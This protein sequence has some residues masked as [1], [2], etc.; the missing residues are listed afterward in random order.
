MW[1]TAVVVA[2]VLAVSGTAGAQ[3]TRTWVSGVG[4]DANPCSRTAPCR[5]FAGAISQ[6]APGGEINAID[7]GGYGAV[8]ITKA[9]TIDGGG[10]FASI[11]ASATTGIVVNAGATDRVVIRNVSINGAPGTG[12]D[13]IRFL[14]GQSLHVE[15]CTIANFSDKGIDF[16]GGGT[17]SVADTAIRNADGGAIE[18]IPGSGSARV[19]V[20]RSRLET[21]LFG[22]HAVGNV[23]ATVVETTAAD[24]SGPGFW[25]DTSPAELNLN[26]VTTAQNDFG[27]RATGGAVVR[28]RGLALVGNATGSFATESGGAIFAFSG[29]LIA[30]NP[31]GGTT[32]CD[33][34][35]GATV[36]DCVDG[37][38]PQPACPAPVLDRVLGTCKKCKTKGGKTVCNGCEVAIE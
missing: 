20:E 17:L 24:N 36:V 22:L 29:D 33:V 25:G 37:T 10:T 14:A 2:L 35:T 12:L 8:T 26:G 27:I 18:V 32:T 34:G 7:P 6:T 11:L 4:N 30:G 21:S 3:A 5:T 38:C 9:M 31:P 19:I 23:L 28:T 15:N 13:G 16:Q 1:R